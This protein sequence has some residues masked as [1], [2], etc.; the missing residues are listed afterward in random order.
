[1]VVGVDA[2]AVDGLHA[3]IG[4][5]LDGRVVEA[6]VRQRQSDLGGL[7][8]EAVEDLLALSLPPLDAV[9]VV[10]AQPVRV[11]P[12]LLP[13]LRRYSARKGTAS[14]DRA[15]DSSGI[16]SRIWFSLTCL[17]RRKP[18]C[19]WKM[20]ASRRLVITTLNSPVACV[21]TLET[22][23][24]SRRSCWTSSASRG[25]RVEYEICTLFRG[26]A[27]TEPSPAN[28]ACRNATLTA[29]SADQTNSGIFLSA[30]RRPS[31]S[32]SRERR[33]ADRSC[34]SSS[35]S[36]DPEAM[37]RVE[38]YRRPPTTRSYAARTSSK[39]RWSMLLK[40][41]RVGEK[42]P[43][44]THA[45]ASRPSAL[46]KRVA[47]PNSYGRGR[48]ITTRSPGATSSSRLHSSVG[49]PPTDRIVSTGW[50]VV[51]VSS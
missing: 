26:R 39:N 24:N 49:T 10:A 7:G 13:C 23:P 44:L 41:A 2:E 36:V 20:R 32:A 3:G 19:P 33:S 31:S 43:S 9:D 47:D 16:L 30:L 42:N 25:L 8:V 21:T 34:T 27:L 1:V 14:S 46:W 11:G 5:G 18:T 51:P 37:T 29:G 17:V 15:D 12:L 4:D 35:R 45:P 40:P 38:R 50:L 6:A 28:R 22:T 48:D